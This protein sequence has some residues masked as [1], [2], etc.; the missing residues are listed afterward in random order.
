MELAFDFLL[1]FSNL[2]DDEIKNLLVEIAESAG[3]VYV[4]KFLSKDLSKNLLSVHDLTSHD[5][6]DLFT[7][8]FAKGFK[9]NQSVAFYPKSKESFSWRVPNNKVFISEFTSSGTAGFKNRHEGFSCFG[10]NLSQGHGLSNKAIRL[11]VQAERVQWI[12]A[13]LGFHTK[14]S[15]VK[16]LGRDLEIPGIDTNILCSKFSSSV[17]QSLGR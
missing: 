2:I 6:D 16:A 5:C 11:K 10:K 4:H 13:T 17:Q 7:D 3:N 14:S 8:T 9:K 12:H 1:L 15:F